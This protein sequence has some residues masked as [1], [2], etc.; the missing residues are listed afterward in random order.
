MFIC[1][2]FTQYPTTE[3]QA[4]ETAGHYIG[5]ELCLKPNL[6]CPHD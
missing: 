6:F 3:V 2:T 4:E 1:L 5:I